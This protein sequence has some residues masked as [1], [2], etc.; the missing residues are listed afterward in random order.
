MTFYIVSIFLYVLA[1][2]LGIVSGFLLAYGYAD[3][4]ERWHDR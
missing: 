2:L 3:Q 4:L 1:W